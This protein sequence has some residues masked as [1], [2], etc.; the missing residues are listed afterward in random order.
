MISRPENQPTELVGTLG[1]APNRNISRDPLNAR[2]FNGLDR[3]LT[4]IAAP[5]GYGKTTLMQDWLSQLVGSGECALWIQV[6]ADKFQTQSLNAQLLQAL[7]DRA[8]P[9][10]G[11]PPN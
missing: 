6:G 4:L 3:K 5:A 8:D 11:Q 7:P 2:F 9:R 10:V 1:D